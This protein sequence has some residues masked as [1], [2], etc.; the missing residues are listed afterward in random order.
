MH[1]NS[2][3]MIDTAI[4]LRLQYGWS[5][6]PLQRERKRPVGKWERFQSSPTSFQEIVS[7]RPE[8]NL[9]LATGAVSGVVV[10][11]C[12]STEDAH[13]FAE[14]KQDSPF[15]VRTPR[16]VHLYFR[17]PGEYVK[18]GQK[19]TDETGRER[20]D[21]R[22]DG[23]Y[24][25]LPPSRVTANGQDCKATGAY[26]WAGDLASLRQLPV[27]QQR[28][29]RQAGPLASKK[30]GGLITDAVAYIRRIHAVSGNGGH[31]DTFRAACKLRDAGL[32]PEE[33]LTELADW[34]QTNCQPPWTMRELLHKVHSAFQG[35]A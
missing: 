26:R 1:E 8:W 22:G 16:G 13:W 7:W 34:N 21:I 4:R 14:H 18:N 17:H 2:T 20:Y 19:I 5:V 11:D 9:G 33:A 32:T 12:E 23:G 6:L 3:S 10:V 27:F 29:G 35:R 31:N 24:V 25:L 30:N 15:K 28:W